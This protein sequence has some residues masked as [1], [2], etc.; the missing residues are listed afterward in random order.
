MCDDNYCYGGGSN[1]M[2]GV[3]LGIL[4]A[5]LLAAAPAIP[6]AMGGW[7]IG[8]EIIGNNF[9]KWGLAITFFLGGYYVFMRLLAKGTIYGV[10][11]VAVQYLTLDA[12]FT[13]Q[14][15]RPE[16]YVISIVKGI[17]AWGVSNT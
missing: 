11:F 13:I 7:Y 16:L 6:V 17:I 1:Y 8:E 2:D 14:D 12:I 4:L 10:I 15:N 3:M 5:V 9:A